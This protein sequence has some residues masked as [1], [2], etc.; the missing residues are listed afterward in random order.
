MNLDN[1][2]DN[3]P[4]S[5]PGCFGEY[6]ADINAFTNCDICGYALQCAMKKAGDD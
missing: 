6:E 5:F 3:I 4:D 2:P 1:A